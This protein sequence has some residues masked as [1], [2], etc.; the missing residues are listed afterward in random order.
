MRLRTIFRRALVLAAAALV[1]PSV[2]AAA[3]NG[4][5]RGRTA[6]HGKVELK[7]GYNPE[8]GV[9]VVKKFAMSAK[10][11]CDDGKVR[12]MSQGFREQWERNRE[13]QDDG[14]FELNREQSS[15]SQLAVHV[16]GKASARAASG[17]A[18]WTLT[19]SVTTFVN[20][21]P[22]VS[23]PITCRSGTQHWSAKAQ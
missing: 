15:T 3:L 17:T 2:A 9:S 23:A 8:W 5:Y 21:V 6:R 12:K 19:Y 16:K 14:S 10:A 13:V 7:I 20:G 18:S 1:V 11:R 4:T 22:K